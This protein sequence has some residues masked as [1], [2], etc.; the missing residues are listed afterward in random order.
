MSNVKGLE[1]L[2]GGDSSDNDDFNE[3]YAGGE[4][5]FVLYCA[6]LVES[7]APCTHAEHIYDALAVAK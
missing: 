3:Y 7:G 1:D 4:K 6:A 5:R 2:G